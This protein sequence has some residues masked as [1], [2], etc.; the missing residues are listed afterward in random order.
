MTVSIIKSIDLQP[1]IA[2]E[3]QTLIPL[4]FFFSQKRNF[5]FYRNEK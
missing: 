3:N 2:S 1:S 5:D 4:E